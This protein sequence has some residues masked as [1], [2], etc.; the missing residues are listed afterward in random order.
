M[1]DPEDVFADSLL[2]LYDHVPVSH[3]S[4]GSVFTYDADRSP[5][6]LVTPDTQAA[7]WAL[8][9]TSIWSAALYVAEHIRDLH[10]EED[11][12]YARR[13][14]RPLRVLEL[15]AGAGL[16]SILIAKTYKDVVVTCSD[17]PDE[18]LIST[19]AENARRNEVSDR[20]RVV[21]YG[22]GS[23]PSTLMMSQH[24]HEDSI[25]G[26]DIILAA[27]TL[28]NSD[29]HRIFIQS[30]QLTLKRSPTA[31]VQLF[32]GLHTGRY[33]IQSFLQLVS[34]A[35]L[36]TEDLRERR[37]DQ[38]G[39]RPWSVQRAEGEDEQERRRWVVWMTLRWRVC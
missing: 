30:L 34:D 13:E 23:D 6:T 8:H 4:A 26:F 39:E 27:D 5:I 10:L 9:A 3:S 21:P 1:S 11:L 15:G 7:N 24:A 32:A 25:P 28:W 12:D 38:S 18:A 29:T 37:V 14:G 33:V 22:W 16:P 2:S 17:Y 36:Y 20:C 35:G 19:L 31:R